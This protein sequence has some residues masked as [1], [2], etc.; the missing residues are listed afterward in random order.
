MFRRPCYVKVGDFVRSK[1]SIE[2]YGYVTWIDENSET[3][4]YY[5]EVIHQEDLEPL[6]F[7]DNELIVMSLINE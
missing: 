7:Y 3:G 4:E 5:V 1:G 6:Y 2:V